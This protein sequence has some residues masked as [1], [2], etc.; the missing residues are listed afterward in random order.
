MAPVS[1]PPAMRRRRRRVR[2]TAAAAFV[3]GAAVLP[4]YLV[5]SAPPMVDCRPWS[6]TTPPT[7]SKS[8]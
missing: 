7:T 3:V 2:A 5:D 6:P 1:G 4:V 8:T